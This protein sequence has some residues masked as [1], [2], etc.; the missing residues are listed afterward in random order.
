M[1]EDDVSAIMDSV[2]RNA[3]HNIENNIDWIDDEDDAMEMAQNYLRDYSSV[4]A[5][6]I[7]GIKDKDT[8][9]DAI[10]EDLLEIAWVFQVLLHYRDELKRNQELESD[11]YLQELL[12]E[13]PQKKTDVKPVYKIKPKNS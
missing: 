8:L 9:M 5:E 13:Q 3:G 2:Y 1:F 11:E 10:T 4:I 6:N 7:N 12:H